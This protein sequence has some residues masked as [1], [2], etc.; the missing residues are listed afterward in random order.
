[1]NTYHMQQGLK[2]SIAGVV[3]AA[4]LL[5]GGILT[6]P[7]AMA[8]EAD[9]QYYS[10]KQPYV[11]PSE[12]TTASYSQAP[13]GYETV[14][15]ESMARHGSRGLSSYKYDA[16]LMKM[17]EAAEADNGFKSDAIKSEFM[18]N[19]K[20]ITA[21]NVENGYGMLT[22][23]GADQHQGI[24]ARAYERNKTLFDNAAKD[25][26]KIAYQSSGEA[27]A[28]ES[29]EN[30]ARGFN[31][32]SNNKLANSTVTPADPAGTG[33]AAAFDKTPNTLYFHK[34]ENP[35]GTEK[36]G[37]AKQRADDY[38]NFVENDAIIAGAEQTIAENEDVK[39]ASHDLLSQIFTDDFL[40][41]LA[42]GT[43]TWYNTVDGTKGGEANCAPGADPSK[44]ADACGAAKKKIASE[45]DAAMDLY[46]LYIIA[47]DMEN[48]N[49]GSHTFDFNQYFQGEQADDA[50]LFAWALDAED[51]Y[52]K[53]PSYAGQDKT[54][55]IAQPLLDDFFSSIDERVNGGSTVATF[56]FAHA[57]T[58]MPFAALL[59]L[60]G[61]TQQAAA[62]TTDVYTYANNEWRGESVTP[63]AA[64]V[65]WDVAVKSG[66]DPKTG[67]AYTPLVRML[68][69]E[70]EIA[71]RSE[72][73]PIAD[74]ST[75]YK[76]TELKSCLASDHQ[77]LGDDARLTD[78]STT[79]PGV[80]PNTGEG[81]STTP[82]NNGAGTH[83]PSNTQANGTENELS[84]TGVAVTG[85]AGIMMLLA[86]AGIS[87]NLWKVR[88]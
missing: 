26:G 67:R 31:A 29:G 70:Q 65:Q 14:Y 23:Q 73:T 50:K 86:L 71:F 87:L 80:G 76:L 60:P 24:G 25:G 49:T 78:D 58:M 53:G 21:A 85:V 45:Y 40:T 62:S 20:A 35:D 16:L 19:L 51:F 3:A 54:Y 43:Y 18:K 32:A 81:T 84:R 69:N 17:A 1:M 52:E 11:A 2:G 79:Q 13:E 46:N 55:T 37:E 82:N 12:A 5:A 22:G 27:R 4:T 68:Y 48:E 34:S 47:A 72:C 44:D 33:E 41:K 9:G 8:L 57:E 28:T 63:M 66:N 38:Q 88:R 6:V 42:D 10:S 59:G 75:W 39:T 15:T 36:T 83:Q 74:G 61:S 64:N 56:R 7:H 77:T 30:F